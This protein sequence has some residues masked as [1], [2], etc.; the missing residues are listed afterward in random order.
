MVLVVA[1]AAGRENK[2]KDQQKTESTPSKDFPRFFGFVL[3]CFETAAV[4][5]CGHGGRKISK[6]VDIRVSSMGAHH[7][8]LL[9][10]CGSVAG[11]P[12]SSTQHSPYIKR[13]AIRCTHTHTHILEGQIERCGWVLLYAGHVCLRPQIKENVTQGPPA[14][15]NKSKEKKKEKK[16]KEKEKR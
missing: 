4:E 9:S 2:E 5:R 7:R 14:E 12:H 3:F 11:R 10:M 1:A 15:E 8:L 16:K 6:D 13:E